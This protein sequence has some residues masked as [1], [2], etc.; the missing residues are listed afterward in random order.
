MTAERKFDLN[1]I[2]DAL[3]KGQADRVKSL[4]SRALASGIAPQEI[5]TEGLLSPMDIISEKF[6]DNLIFTPEVL[7]ASR[8]MHAGMHV[9]KPYLSHAEQFY[10]GKVVMGTVV[11]DLHDIGKNLVVM[12]MRGAGLEVVDLGVDIYPE[13]FAGAVMEHGPDI[14]AM[15][16]LLT[17]TMPAMAETIRELEKEN[18]RRRVKVLVGGGPVTEDFAQ[19]IKA[20]GYAPDAR[21]AAELAVK[22]VNS[23]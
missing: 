2:T 4:V 18:L 17:T 10:G 23:I 9:L 3:L 21:K 5:V 7:I 16:A 6:R 20:D 11:G 12:M 8:A 14:V 15:S 19:I 1:L 22:L 13:D